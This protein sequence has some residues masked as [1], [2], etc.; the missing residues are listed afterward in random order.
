MLQHSSYRGALTAARHGTQAPAVTENS[1]LRIPLITFN[2]LSA[3]LQCKLQTQC[4]SEGKESPCAAAA[5]RRSARPR[6][7]GGTAAAAAG[8]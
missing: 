5:A 6:R 7:V 3:L 8:R 1:R 4:L 2:Q